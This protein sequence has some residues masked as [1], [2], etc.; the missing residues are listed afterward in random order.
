MKS[1]F[2]SMY[3]LTAR[4]GVG[5][6]CDEQGIALGPVV[7][8]EAL[9]AGGRRV[10]R[11]RP[12][13]EIA[14]TLALAYDDLAP[15]DIARCLSSLDVAAKALEARDLANASV[16]AVLLKLPD[17]SV[18]GFARLAADPSLKKYS[19]SQPRDERGR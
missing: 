10:F 4:G 13:E 8:V 5:L 12:A 3:R 17:L 7:L 19:S 15:T 18:D 6:A 1:P 16:A 14:R 2:P 11:P 9:A